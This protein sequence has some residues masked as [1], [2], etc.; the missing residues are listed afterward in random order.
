M[1]RAVY[2]TKRER[3]SIVGEFSENVAGDEGIAW[4]GLCLVSV[5]SVF[6]LKKGVKK[7]GMDFS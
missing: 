7:I 5:W 2:R 3:Q 1:L 6:G 4:R